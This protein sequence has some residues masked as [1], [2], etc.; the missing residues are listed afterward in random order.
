MDETFMRA[1]VNKRYGAK[2][3]RDEYKEDFWLKEA[4]FD[5]EQIENDKRGLQGYLELRGIERN[6]DKTLSYV[7]ANATIVLTYIMPPGFE[8]RETGEDIEF[9]MPRYEILIKPIQQAETIKYRKYVR[10]MISN[11]AL[12]SVPED[13][14]EVK[15]FGYEIYELKGG[16]EGDL[17]KTYTIVP[18]HISQADEFSR[19]YDEQLR[20][21]YMHELFEAIRRLLQSSEGGIRHG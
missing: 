14:S 12:P 11:L 3:M 1:Y 9:T 17:W 2:D 18:F 21:L 8:I 20:T 15:L 6:A 7:L 5:L 10:E 19:N 4:V 16:L 13:S